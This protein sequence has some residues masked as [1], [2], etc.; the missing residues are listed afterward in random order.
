VALAIEAVAKIEQA[1]PSAATASLVNLLAINNSTIR[2]YP[3]SS[4]RTIGKLNSR[5]WVF[6]DPSRLFCPY[7][8]ILNHASP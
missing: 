4:N 6:S 7:S 1:Q 5:Q 2:S 8:L 3:K